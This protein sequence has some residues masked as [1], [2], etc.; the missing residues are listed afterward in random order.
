MKYFASKNIILNY[1]IP[2]ADFC[3]IGFLFSVNI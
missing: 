2:E 3:Y 1:F